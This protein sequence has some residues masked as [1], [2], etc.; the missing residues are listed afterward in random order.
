MA[1]TTPCCVICGKTAADAPNLKHCAKCKTSWY[2]SREYLRQQRR[3]QLEHNTN[4]QTQRAAN[5]RSHISKPFTA[6]DNNTWLHDRAEGDVFK[7]LID[8]TDSDSVYGGNSDSL[9]GFRRFIRLVSSRAGLLPP[10]WSSDKQAECEA[11]GMGNNWSSLKKM[12]TKE[13]IQAHYGED[14]MPM[15]MRMFAEAVYH[16]GPGGQ[17]GTAMRKMMAKMEQSDGVDGEQV[18]SM[19]SLNSTNPLRR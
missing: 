9:P 17:D 10:W 8:G 3:L 1:D 16:R 12:T 4:Y 6:L 18:M 19:L 15:Q 2:C 7:L 14:K 11:F 13:Q 5:L